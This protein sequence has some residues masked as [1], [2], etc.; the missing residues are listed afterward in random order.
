MCNKNCHCYGIKLSILKCILGQH[1]MHYNIYMRIV[2]CILKL[3]IILTNK[4]TEE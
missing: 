1:T 4:E 3:F 2:H